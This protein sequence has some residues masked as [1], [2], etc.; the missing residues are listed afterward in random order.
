MRLNPS[1]LSN[2]N[3]SCSLIEFGFAAVAS[4]A[5]VRLDDAQLIVLH[6]YFMF[7]YCDY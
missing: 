5:A 1:P 7:L 6:D 2:P 4:N 3:I